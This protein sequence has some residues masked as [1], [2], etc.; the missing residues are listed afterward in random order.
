MADFSVGRMRENYLRRKTKRKGEEKRSNP[1]LRES[2]DMWVC[3]L[4]CA[5]LCGEKGGMQHL[6]MDY[7]RGTTV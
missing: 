7:I 5:C 2:C 1:N 6:G 4:P 3:V